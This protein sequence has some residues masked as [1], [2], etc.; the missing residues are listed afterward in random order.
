MKDEGAGPASRRVPGDSLSFRL[1]PSAFILLPSAFLLRFR[2]AVVVAHPGKDHEPAP[3]LPEETGARY[4][5]GIAPPGIMPG[6]PIPGIAPC[7]P[8]PAPCASISHSSRSTWRCVGSVAV[9]KSWPLKKRTDPCPPFSRH[10]CGATV[11]RTRD[12]TW[13]PAL[14]RPPMG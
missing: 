5:A 11:S 8:P 4:L 2:G 14:L 13:P 6:I 1:H 3:R 12:S 7:P 9:T 10:E